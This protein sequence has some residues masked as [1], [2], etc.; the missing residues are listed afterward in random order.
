MHKFILGE[1]PQAPESGG[2]WIIHLPQ[3]QAIIEAVIDGAKVH[4]NHAQYV[5]NYK[6]VNSDGIA[7]Q[8]Q[9]RLYHYFSGEFVDDLD[10]ERLAHKMLNDAWAWYKSYLEWEDLNIDLNDYEKEN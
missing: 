1:N 7:E 6:H 9:L 4:S 3:P 10:D 5:A 2:M 8:W